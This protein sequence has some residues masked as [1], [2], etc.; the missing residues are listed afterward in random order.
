MDFLIAL[1]ISIASHYGI[2][3][4]EAKQTDE[5]KQAVEQAQRDGVIVENDI[6]G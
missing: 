5:F 2:S 6:I 4:A 3:N 1:L